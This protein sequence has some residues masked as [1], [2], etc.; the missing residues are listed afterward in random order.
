LLEQII[1]DEKLAGVS[2]D[3]A[4]DP[5]DCHEAIA[6]CSGQAAIPTRKNAKLWKTNRYGADT[7]S[8]ILYATRRLD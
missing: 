1:A 5:Q 4:Y 3:G 6:L 7:R 8:G 2:G